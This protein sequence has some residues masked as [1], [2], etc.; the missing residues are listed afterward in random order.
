MHLVGAEFFQAGEGTDKHTW[1]SYYSLF[2]IFERAC[3]LFS[4]YSLSI[5]ISRVL[6]IGYKKSVCETE[7]VVSETELKG[8]TIKG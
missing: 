2:E 7:R 5:L 3:K 6:L 8:V 4:G 1:R